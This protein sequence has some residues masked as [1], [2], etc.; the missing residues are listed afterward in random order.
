M[1]FRIFLFLICLTLVSKTGAQEKYDIDWNYGDLTL[2]EFMTRAGDQFNLKFLYRDEWI[3]GLELEQYDNCN[4][5]ACILDNLFSNKSLYYFIDAS[6]NVIITK[7]FAINR[8][9]TNEENKRS[10][11]IESDHFASGSDSWIEDMP[12]VEIGNR[13][14]GSQQGK[15]VLSGLITEQGTG[16]PAPGVTVFIKSMS[17][18]SV[19][20]KNGRYSL[21]LRRGYY[22]VQFTSIG[23]KEKKV[24]LNLYGSGELNIVM[25]KSMV[26]LDEIFISAGRNA[27]LSQFETGMEKINVSSSRLIPSSMGEKDI[28]KSVT[29]L[30]G[31]QSSEGSSGFNVRG[32]SADQNLI[33]LHGAPVYNSSHFFGFFS[34]VNSDLISDMTLYKGGIPGRFGGRISSVLDIETK[35]GN[36]REFAGSLGISPITA[37]LV[38]E[39]PVIKD[40]L[41]YL[42]TARSTYSNWILGL[43]K[44]PILNNTEASFHDLNGKITYKWNKA[45]KIDL[46]SYYSHDNFRFSILNSTYKYDNYIQAIKWTH[47]FNSRFS[48][49][50]LFNNSAYGYSI[51]DRNNELEAY[52]LSHK[53]NSTELKTDFNWMPGD[54]K[55]NFGL[56]I[57]K[58]SV[59]PGSID[60]VSDSS[61]ILM[62]FIDREEAFESSVYID[63]SFKLTKFLS[64]NAGI[65]LSSFVSLGPQTVYD[66]SPGFSK[67]N[68]TIT[69]TTSIRSGKLYNY[70]A[71]PELR[72]SLN[73]K[74]SS[75]QSI[76]LN[77]NSTRQYLH[78]LS[79]S[80][81]VSPTDSWKLSDPYLKP[82]IG[83]QYA[84]GFYQI[85]GNNKFETSVEF[86]SKE[87]QNMVDYKG[88][89]KLTMIDHIEQYM[90]NV[91]GR[92]YGMELVLKKTEGRTHFN[93]AY[94]YS[95]TLLK[96]TSRFRDEIINSG[97]WYPANYDKP[98]NLILS[99]QYLYSRRLSFSADYT[100]T[101]GR[102]MT[103]PVSSYYAGNVFLINYSDRNKYRIPDYS[104]LDVSCKISGNLK[105]K[106]IAHPNLTLSVYNLFGR[107]N[108]YSVYFQQEGTAI[109]GYKM[110]IFGRPI[111][112]ATFSFDF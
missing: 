56:D 18:G 50:L 45:N 48:S 23:F 9:D 12:V 95:R 33:L 21:S 89:S 40:K 8:S 41:S 70:N 71:G 11:L 1:K 99:Y 32:G 47:N 3:D 2:K 82:E 84:L 26:E 14:E 29:M 5:L 44:N 112:S 7:G 64:L 61:N 13:K 62:R 69:D 54:H 80:T 104:R 16:L 59:L 49:L 94:T 27:L 57:T 20:D 73:F 6:H 91:K 31:V 42:V 35:E 63:E 53:I 79:N 55:I 110:S 10:F 76:K 108:A 72:L 100:Y 86:Y 4:N 75:R 88:G 106:K 43:I 83:Q 46:L 96:S 105:S 28:M 109:K 60:P 24:S 58:Y 101:T 65:R 85:F 87:I 68:S 36:N 77:Y 51:S 52:R 111:P 17:A 15:V 98:N 78:L 25:N 22:S 74:I 90:I 81:S 103:L 34:A 102:P 107:E 30:P 38:V 97:H 93:L 66:Y 92:A 19:S 37:S 67:T 39:G